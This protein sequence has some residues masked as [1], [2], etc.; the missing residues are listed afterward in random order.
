MKAA[1]KDVAPRLPLST[2]VQALAE[3]YDLAMAP[4]SCSECRAIHQEFQ[5]ALA[6][7]KVRLSDRSAAPDHLA[8]WI[9]GLDEECARMRETSSVWATWRR[10]QEHRALTGHWLSPLPVPPNS[11]S[12]KN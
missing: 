12:S 9:Q 8:A 2:L 4:S 3:V 11:M 5:E 6:A 10:L 7:A 1:L